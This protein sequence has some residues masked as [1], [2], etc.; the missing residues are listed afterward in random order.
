MKKSIFALIILTLGLCSLSAMADTKI[1]TLKKSFTALETSAGVNVVY[2]PT[3]G[4][5]YGT[6]TLSGDANRIENVDVKIKSNKLKISVKSKN[7]IKSGNHIK[8][9]LITINAPMAMDFDASSGSHIRC[10]TPIQ[11]GTAKMDLE[12]SSGASINF[13]GITCNAVDLDAS[14]GASIKIKALRTNKASL[15]ASSG[16]GIS[17]TMA[18]IGTCNSDA[19][20]G[21]SIKL[22]GKAQKGFFSASSGGSIRGKGFIVKDAKI[23][24]SLSGSVKIDSK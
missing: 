19:S 1:L 13:A 16:S 23:D 11:M 2:K 21:A 6:I 4:N 7:G 14:S 8:G 24:R 5:G 10:A 22:S 3:S 20:S 12:A 18:N 15:D 9:V 17:L